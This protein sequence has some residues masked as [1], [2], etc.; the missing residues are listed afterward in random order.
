MK[1]LP[2]LLRNGIRGCLTIAVSGMV[3]FSV[4]DAAPVDAS[5]VTLGHV[6][7][8]VRSQYP[9]QLAALIEQDIANGRVRA[10]LGAFDWNLNAG[11]TSN[12]AGYYDGRSGFANLEKPLSFWGGSVYGGYRLSSGFLPNYSKERTGVDGEA[13]LGFKV[14]LLRDGTI[15]RRRATL[16]QAEIDQQLAEPFIL[17]QYLDFV[18]ASTIT[19]YT[20]LAAGKRL[21]FAEELLRIAERRDSA[22]A[23]QVLRG[24]SARIV[25]V[26]NKRL[27]VSRQISVVQAKRRFE[28]AAIELSLFLRNKETA[29]PI[30]AKREQLPADFPSH[31]T[32]KYSQMA[33]DIDTAW[34]RRPEVRR[35][36]LTIE[37]TNID[38]RLAKNNLMPSLE[39]GVNARQGVGG[40][41]PKDIEREEVEAK[42]EFRL[43][44]ERREAK[45]RLDVA[46]SQ[47]SRLQTERQFAR[48]RIAADV[49]DSYSAL[50]AAQDTLRQTRIN[51]DLAQ[52]LEDAE[53]EKLEHGATDLLALQIR[54]QATFDARVLEVDALLEH[55]RA[56]ANYRAAVAADAPDPAKSRAK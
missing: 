37:K 8:S 56:E 4:C 39:L 5:V 34:I 15:D 42:L 21:V 36:E 10:A 33:A 24:A 35:I 26:D 22:I 16:W 28:A 48:D 20:W 12:L 29:E 7:E 13:V 55:F 51:V 32:P 43:P 14:P 54:E 40:N 9:P 19:Y 31:T 3:V 45:G 52:Q 46:Q 11:G 18:R 41:R 23:E 47:I 50:I 49:R 17:R 2:P 30:L 25:Q 44:L 27:V 6:V 53:N 1:F 38:M